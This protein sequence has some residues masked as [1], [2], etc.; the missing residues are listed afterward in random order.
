M[1]D[2]FAYYI[3]VC[4]NVKLKKIGFDENN[5]YNNDMKLAATMNLR[6]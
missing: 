2:V 3:G 4:C 1:N 5:K 6:I